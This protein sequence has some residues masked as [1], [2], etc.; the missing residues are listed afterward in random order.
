MPPVPAEESAPVEPLPELTGLE[1]WPHL[2]FG[3]VIEPDPARGV[4]LVVAMSLVAPPEPPDAPDLEPPAAAKAEPPVSALERYRA[5]A[6]QWDEADH[7]VT[8]EASFSAGSLTPV[9]SGAGAGILRDNVRAIVA[10]LEARDTTG[11]SRLPDLR[12]LVFALPDPVASPSSYAKKPLLPLTVTLR[13]RR[14]AAEPPAPAVPAS[15][16]TITDTAAAPV[17]RSRTTLMSVPPRAEAGPTPPS[18]RAF[19]TELE[20]AYAEFGWRVLREEDEADENARW[21]LLRWQTTGGV[22]ISL[23]AAEAPAAAGFACPRLC[24]TGL[25]RTD[26]SAALLPDEFPKRFAGADVHTL[27]DFDLDAELARFLDDV[28]AFLAPAW[29]V[30]AALIEPALVARGVAAKETLAAWLA[31]LVVPVAPHEPGREAREAARA[32]LGG[33]CR[34]DLRNFVRV[35][36]VALLQLKAETPLPLIVHGCF[37]G[38]AAAPEVLATTVSVAAKENVVAFPVCARAEEGDDCIDLDGSFRCEAITSTDAETTDGAAGRR[39]RFVTQGGLHLP[40]PR[41]RARVPWRTMP[42][43]PHVRSQSFATDEDGSVE[44]AKSWRLSCAWTCEAERSDM[45]RFGVAVGSVEPA[46]T[47]PASAAA[48]MR[49]DLLDTLV[50][51]RMCLPAII[52]ELE[53]GLRPRARAGTPPRTAPVREA[54]RGFVVLME[55]VARHLVIPASAPVELPAGL[56][57]RKELPALA[58]GVV[59]AGPFNIARDYAARGALQLVRNRSEELAPAFLYASRVAQAPETL[60]VWIDRELPLDL[61][62]LPP[63]P[64]FMPGDP[65]PGSLLDGLARLLDAVVMAPGPKAGV[66]LVTVSTKI[67][68]AARVAVPGADGPEMRL[69]VALMAPWPLSPARRPSEIRAWA[70]LVARHLEQWRKEND[71]RSRRSADGAGGRFVFEL[72]LRA[73][74]SPGDAGRPIL[75]LSGLYFPIASA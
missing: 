12:P 34:M 15:V 49:P 14:A 20:A 32:A 65:L 16:S 70:E 51:A 56:T 2:E 58:E 47:G 24:P 71:P 43:P 29:R 18:H 67:E 23:H 54:I 52:A 72:T 22:Q 19:A 48:E 40:A 53:Q 69:P 31:G 30:P 36:A 45:L 42:P 28:E 41:L 66:P 46:A 6:G 55:W 5:I 11:T 7:E 64:D 68:F 10:A 33:A 38:D 21:F 37:E 74:E 26:L 25:S 9:G 8:A 17:E 3:Y 57:Q 4:R 75:R 35:G 1:S 73:V 62:A 59:T 60:H 63:L 44:A 27:T 50:I 61:A 13:F 39:L